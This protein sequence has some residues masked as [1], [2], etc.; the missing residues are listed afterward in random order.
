MEEP[1]NC[2]STKSAPITYVHLQG[3]LRVDCPNCL[4]KTDD[5]VIGELE[6]FSPLSIV[7]HLRI[8]LSVRLLAKRNFTLLV[9]LANAFSGPG[10]W[11]ATV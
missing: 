7:V 1:E 5:E 3:V 8:A 10:S 4:H 2:R 9:V 6:C 11:P